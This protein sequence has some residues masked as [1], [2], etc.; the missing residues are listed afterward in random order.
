MLVPILLALAVLMGLFVIV[1]AMRPSDF[2]VT[3]SAAMAAQAEQVFPHVNELRNWEAWNPWGKLDPNCKMTYDGPAAG[4]GASYA[5]A[6]NNKIGEGRNTIT[7][8]RPSELVRFRL[9]FAKPMKATNTA[10]FTF[11][12][13]GDRTVETVL[14]VE[15]EAQVRSLVRLVL[16]SGGY[17]VL[18]ADCGER[19]IEVA[20]RHPEAIDLLLTDV[21]MP[22]MNGRQ[23]A[24][25]LGS[26]RPDLKV[27]YMS[28]YTDDAALTL[29][30][31]PASALFI[32]KPFAPTA[33]AGRV[34]HV[35]A[36]R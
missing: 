26:R 7:E 20:E 36:G 15:D 16:E 18:E 31:L 10:E 22:G 6:G 9:E 27:I 2:R 19:G 14:L 32:Q 33:L 13:E 11:Q 21:V 29:G 23:L 25:R 8:S 4:V 12:P 5:W 24:E 1:V 30:P 17:R 35:L 28:G 3:R 34:R